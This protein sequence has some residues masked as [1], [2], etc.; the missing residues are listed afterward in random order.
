MV[1]DIKNIG[2]KWVEKLL[3]NGDRWEI[4]IDEN[5]FTESLYR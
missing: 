2:I 4:E 3:K 1:E 5:L